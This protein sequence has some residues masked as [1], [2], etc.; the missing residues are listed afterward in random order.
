MTSAVLKDRVRGQRIARSG[1][2]VI[3]TRKCHE[4]TTAERYQSWIAR[5]PDPARI[6]ARRHTT[7]QE[8]QHGTQ[9]S[10]GQ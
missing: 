6:F 2:E 9:E 8:K 7:K 10:T 3:V 1:G 4:P 5:H